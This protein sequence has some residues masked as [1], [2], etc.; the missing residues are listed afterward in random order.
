[1]LQFKSLFLELFNVFLLIEVFPLFLSCDAKG[2]LYCQ[3]LH[4]SLGPPMFSGLQ[5]MLSMWAK[6]CFV[7]FF[8]QKRAYLVSE[9][10]KVLAEGE[11]F[12]FFF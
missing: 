4:A 8:F 11:I 6:S 10:R 2:F 5:R 3:N 1:M 12:F 7:N 9:N